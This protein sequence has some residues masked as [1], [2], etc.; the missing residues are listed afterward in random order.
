M[1]TALISFSVLLS[2]AL[3]ARA[4]TIWTGTHVEVDVSAPVHVGIG[5]EAV[6][7]T[8]V[9]LGGALPNAFDGVGSVGDPHT[10][11][12]TSGDGLHQVF[13]FG[14]QAA[15]T[16]TLTVISPGD[17]AYQP[18]DTHFLVYNA[19]IIPAPGEDPLENQL[20]QYTV[21]N[22]DG[23]FGNSLTGAFASTVTPT[24]SWDFAYIVT[25]PGTTV[26]LDFYLAFSAINITHELVG[27]SFTIVPEPTSILLWTIAALGLA[28]ARFRRRR[29]P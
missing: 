21:E 22:P 17:A 18:I 8:A 10:G 3:S 15:Q 5:L 28:A 16:P 20:V 23:G 6:T 2:L 1:K 25:L 19:G 12:T 27:T 24:S 11:I 14:Y 4:D 26:N 7:L 13:E 29:T 9:G